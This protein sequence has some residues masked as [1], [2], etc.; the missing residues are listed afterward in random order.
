M[1]LHPLPSALAFTVCGS[2]L[3]ELFSIAWY[4]ASLELPLFF[5]PTLDAPFTLPTSFVC[6]RDLFRA[7]S[8]ESILQMSS[9]RK[10]PL[11]ESLVG[12]NFRPCF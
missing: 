5:D 9:S 7:A 1:M 10:A 11:S 3:L 12:S 6:T 4:F 2:T 8:S